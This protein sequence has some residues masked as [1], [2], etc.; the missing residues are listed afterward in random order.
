MA[1]QREILELL[2]R[3]AG[4]DDVKSLREALKQLEKQSEGSGEEA[5]ALSDALNAMAGTA[6]QVSR[7]INLK[8]ALKDTS[9]SLAQAEKGLEALNAE[10]SVTDR[11]SP[12]INR[13]F[14]QAEKAVADL[15]ARQREQ[16]LE[17][18]KTNGELD[19][20]GVDTGALASEY[21]R[22]EDEIRASTTATTEQ[23]RRLTA[24]R[25]AAQQLSER[26][27]KLGASLRNAAQQANE[28]GGR[29][30]KIGAVAATA[31]AALAAFQTGRQF[32]GA[33]EDAAN[34][35]TLLARIQAKAGIA[36]DEIDGVKESIEGI[37]AES[38]KGVVEA[39]TAYEA[40]AAE[41]ASAEDALAQL[42]PTLDF[43]TAAQLDGAAA[44]ATLS[45]ALDAFQEPASR[46]AA[47]A[48]LIAQGALSGGTGIKDLSAALTQA[49]PA[50]EQAEQSLEAT[51]AQIGRLAQAG[52]EGGR[53]GSALR[54]ILVE[55]Q[56][57]SSAL[58]KEL[59]ALGISTRSLD[60]V[61]A[62]LSTRGEGAEAVFQS[63]GGRSA[64]A[65]RALAQDGGAAL[66]QL[67][68]D[69][70]GSEGAASRAAETINS[71]Y[72]AALA[73]LQQ[74][75]Q[76][77]RREL[78]TPLLEP[79]SIEIDGIA[80]AIREF[81][82]GP[83]F[84][85]IRE[86]LPELFKAGSE[87][88]K[89]FAADVDLREITDRVV[90]FAEQTSSRLRE[91]RDDA[92][93]VRDVIVGT[94]N[95]VALLFNG[96]QAFINASAV[97]VS[98][99]LQIGAQAELA[100][101]KARLAGAALLGST[102]DQ[103][104][105]LENVNRAQSVADGLAAAAAANY[106]DLG[107]NVFEAT[108][109]FKRLA[110]ESETAS[111]AVAG[112]A[113]RQAAAAQSATP[114]I[115]DLSIT[116]KALT[117]A[118]LA[119]LDSAD[120][121]AESTVRQGETAADS[122]DAIRERTEAEI[123]AAKAIGGTASASDAAASSSNRAAGAA[124]N[125][126]AANKDAADSSKQA[127]AAGDEQAES[128]NNLTL[129]LFETSEE[130]LRK[131][132]DANKQAIISARAF[133]Q[134][135]NRVTAE[136]KAQEKDANFYLDSLRAQTTETDEI[137]VR[138]E[139]LRQQYRLL[140]DAKLREIALAEQRL[141]QE[142][143]AFALDQDR[144]FQGF[145]AARAR[146]DAEIEA[147]NRIAENRRRIAAEESPSQ[148]SS[149]APAA[150]TTLGAIN[151]TINGVIAENEREFARRLAPLLEEAFRRIEQ[152]RR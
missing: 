71:T 23:A 128:M 32:T 92:G 125:Q 31:F 63:L 39:A 38:S 120:A 8:A 118:N 143:K 69:L 26:F 60:G 115:N 149:A 33:I 17:L 137:T 123:E 150:S 4:E 15:T 103:L 29:L 113:D 19:K 3:T 34:L 51:V 110:G 53:A 70:E 108:D 77:A 55:L 94:A 75:Y 47:V 139:R 89:A 43:A 119:Y 104:E 134:A 49:G 35:E 121:A 147:D 9:D 82:D 41:G 12:A 101:A 61:I 14:K 74:S 127:A 73:R 83:D 48:D 67:R 140:S 117:E 11:S 78:V 142:N 88:V 27:D 79:L 122:A 87:A 86:Q 45:A 24:S 95:G 76:D 124:S 85:R 62:E 146:A 44:V 100:I 46:T 131:Y 152:L 99:V 7:S 59:D 106:E 130:G 96:V 148:T 68:A 132:M 135:V 10:F 105:A 64:I 22:L 84:A 116:V 107:R 36:S 42:K 133:A 141:A 114:R 129:A 97:V 16:Q 2:L 72:A 40:L 109:A 5:A 6:A 138:V 144:S 52:I 80:Q 102:Q 18:A 90:Q 58:S 145:E 25:E 50:A 93:N 20:A 111:N 136:I 91:F 112:G 56:D 21:Q 126:A 151:I 13:A 81:T 98:R 28:I 37:A 57:P 30:V 1:T 65:L 66:Q 54:G